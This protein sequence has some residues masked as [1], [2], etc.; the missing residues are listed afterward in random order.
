MSGALS[1]VPDDIDVIPSDDRR[2]ALPAMAGERDP[3]VR[4]GQALRMPREVDAWCDAV[5][6]IDPL[7]VNIL[8]K[9][10]P[11]KF[12][13]GHILVMGTTDAGKTTCITQILKDML[14]QVG[15]GLGHRVFIWDYKR[16]AR[17]YLESPEVAGLKDASGRPVPIYYLDPVDARSHGIDWPREIDSAPAAMQFARD[18]IQPEA[19]PRGHNAAF[20]QNARS[21]VYQ[22]VRTFQ[23]FAPEEWDLMD[24]V[25]ACTTERNLRAVLRKTARG[26]GM[27]ET[28]FGARNQGKGVFFSIEP[29]LFALGPIAAALSKVPRERR[30]TVRDD[31][32]KREAVLVLGHS[33]DYPEALAA[34]QTWVFGLVCR[35]LLAG[36]SIP[37]DGTAR[38]SFFLDEV[39]N[40]PFGL[41]LI[42][43]ANSS[44]SKGGS[45]IAGIG[46]ESGI[47][48]LL[49][50]HKAN[51]FI[52]M[53][54]TKVFLFMT[55]SSAKWA[56]EYFGTN[57]RLVNKYSEGESVG[58][59]MGMSFSWQ[60]S[61]STGR[62]PSDQH[63]SGFSISDQVS[64]G[65]QT[66][67][68]YEAVERPVVREGD[69][70]E[71]GAPHREP[72]RGLVVR[73]YLS[74]QQYAWK[75]VATHMDAVSLCANPQTVAIVPRDDAEF[76]FDDGWDM[77]DFRRLDLVVPDPDAAAASP[78]GLFNR[79]FTPA[80][81]TR[82]RTTPD[83]DDDEDDVPTVDEARDEGIEFEPFE[84]DE[85][86]G[87]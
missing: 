5:R 62:F 55:G 51:E 9:A 34:F 7:H 77:E 52:N 75:E 72:G 29:M 23:K 73:G 12:A 61:T 58:R 2:E 74:V 70:V 25:N 59:S 18:L 15:G 13:F 48:D 28:V 66:N 35:R 79:T 39:R 71:L 41:Q 46:D 14:W 64:R 54:K 86:R 6:K 69:F 82:P 24:V 40:S 42:K 56:R 83:S 27:L 1:D 32:L 57:L 36:P 43:L 78:Q 49:G 81:G 44:R 19:D 53:F 85:F 3:C 80:A 4:R 8:S 10:I 20:T 30:I 22:V 38:T 67:T 68:S 63:S 60:R 17:A 84:L 11:H 26:Q 21:V 87:M 45:I 76:D 37:H 16:E 33:E 47:K 65:H 31:W 50:D